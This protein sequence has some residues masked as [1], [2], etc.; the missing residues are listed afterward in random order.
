MIG[1]LIFILTIILIIQN[2]QI[3]KKRIKAHQLLIDAYN[4]SDTI[5]K[6]SIDELNKTNKLIRQIKYTNK[7]KDITFNYYN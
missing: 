3:F 2:I 7:L 5:Y 1:I 6:T 4:K